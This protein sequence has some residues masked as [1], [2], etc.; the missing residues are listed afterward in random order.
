[1]CVWGDRVRGG[2]KERE[3]GKRG[4]KG[5]RGNKCKKVKREHPR[6][7]LP[8]LKSHACQLQPTDSAELYLLLSLDSTQGER[9]PATPLE[10]GVSQSLWTYSSNPLFS[11]L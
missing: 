2:E 8:S 6:H 5:E 3:G 4:R 7:T 1:M 10:R 9:D 11:H